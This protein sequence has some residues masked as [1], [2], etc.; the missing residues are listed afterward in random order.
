M[1]CEWWLV[2]KKKRFIETQL[3]HTHRPWHPKNPNSCKKRNS[4]IVFAVCTNSLYYN[5]FKTSIRISG[6]SVSKFFWRVTF[7]QPGFKHINQHNW[8]LVLQTREKVH[9]PCPI[10]DKDATSFLGNSFE[11]EAC[12]HT[13][14]HTQR[15]K[16]GNGVMLCCIPARWNKRQFL[17]QC[18]HTD[19]GV[20]APTLW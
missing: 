10:W 7:V 14:K 2:E 4:K 20:Q 19:A 8:K 16:G 6:I 3:Q 9:L 5:I 13:Q 17:F 1:H 18:S 11:K 12:L 15:K